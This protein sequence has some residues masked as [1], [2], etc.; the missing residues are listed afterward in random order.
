MPTRRMHQTTVRF[1]SELWQE[2]ERESALMGVSIAQYIR[3][4][5][6][7]R[8]IHAEAER[9]GQEFGLALE[10]ATEDEQPPP[11]G[12]LE[13]AQ[14]VARAESEAGSAAALWAQGRQ[15]RLRAR[16]LREDVTR[17]RA[18]LS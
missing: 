5:A 10:I 2:L 17:R 12:Q 6:L 4:A 18:T 15:A 14:A 3:E 1:G 7:A 11:N 8:L 9:G 13:A 16:Q